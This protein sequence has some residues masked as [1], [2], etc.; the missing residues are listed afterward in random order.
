MSEG[1]WAASDV[2]IFFHTSVAP[3]LLAVLPA[4]SI[5]LIAPAIISLLSISVMG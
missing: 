5:L 4:V 3:P 1:N 2:I